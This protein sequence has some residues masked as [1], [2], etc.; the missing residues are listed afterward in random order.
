[1]AAKACA[2]GTMRN[3]LPFMRNTAVTYPQPLIPSDM[4]ILSE[5]AVLRDNLKKLDTSKNRCSP[6]ALMIH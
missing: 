6:K 5:Y 2:G 4:A 3:V 1:M